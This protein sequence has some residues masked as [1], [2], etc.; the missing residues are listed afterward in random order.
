MLGFVAFL[1]GRKGVWSGRVEK[2]RR[3][4]A[5]GGGGGRGVG[6]MGGFRVRARV[7][8]A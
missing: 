7:V 8:R 5:S 2:G 1:K 4:G 3:G 6:G